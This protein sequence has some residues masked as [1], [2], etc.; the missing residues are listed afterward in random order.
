M[1]GAPST[2]RDIATS[3]MV[4]VIPA[5]AKGTNK[6]RFCR[7]KAFIRNTT[8]DRL[9]A[10]WSAIHKQGN[11]KKNVCDPEVCSGVS[12]FGRRVVELNLKMSWLRLWM[13]L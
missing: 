3:K 4:A 10:S 1:H 5:S 12:L 13:G 7:A 9:T 2:A 6:G 11:E 8:A